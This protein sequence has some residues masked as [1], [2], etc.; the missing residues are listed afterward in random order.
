MSSFHFPDN[1]SKEDND[2]LERCFQFQS[3]EQA[4]VQFSKREE[5]EASLR[6]PEAVMGNHFIKLWWAN[7]DCIPSENN[8]T[9]EIKPQ[10]YGLTEV[11]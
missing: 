5:A 3:S 11:V 9:D 8:A 2:E 10:V 7:R 6:T 1:Q 4:F